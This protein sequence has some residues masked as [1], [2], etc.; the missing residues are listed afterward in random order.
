MLSILHTADFHLDA[1]FAA[2][3]PEQGAVRRGQQRQLLLQLAEL[4]RK[5][6]GDL[7]LLSGDVFDGDAVRPETVD[8][9]K[10]AFAACGAQVCIAPGNHDPYT[11]DSVWHRQTW[12]ENVHIFSGSMEA[13]SFPELH[14]RVW[15]AAFRSSCAENLLRP[16][17][18]AQ[19]G[20]WEIGVFHGDPV[21][22]GNYHAI[23]KETLQTCGL[24]YLALGHIH[25]TSLPQQLG[26]TYYGWPGAAAAR[27]F[28]E[29][30]PRY[31]F[32]VQLS[33]R[34]CET[35]QIPLPG[36]TYETVTVAA[37]DDPEAAVRRVLPADGQDTVC[38]VTLTGEA[39]P[40]DVP[41]LE[42]RLWGL[43]LQLEIRDE[44]VP[45]RDLWADC[46]TPTLRGL[47][48]T[49]L[50]QQHDAGDVHAALAARYLLAALDVP[51]AYISGPAG[52]EHH[53]WNLLWLDGNPCWMDPTWGDPV[54]EGGNANDGPS[55]EYFAMTTEQLLRT[56]TPDDAVPVP[57]CTTE[58]Y[59]YFRKNG[60]YLESY[61][62]RAV[63]AALERA[64]TEG[65]T[66][67]PL[68][69]A[70][71]AYD[72]AVS[73]LFDQGQIYDLLDEASGS[74]GLTLG[75]EQTLWYSENAPMYTVSLFLPV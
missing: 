60:L 43:C 39:E 24:D 53:A 75:R 10:A 70:P 34:G 73:L 17:P 13:F 15:G 61:D 41:A 29:T 69:F 33:D 54:Y 19:D 23:S 72:E 25:K 5:E 68:Q 52:G 67:V 49:E 71:G 38:R 48:L 3:T 45:P 9:M 56:H 50:K 12:P 1:P 7:W 35:R 18:E 55:Y 16:I 66:K 58:A 28:D 32:W 14:C 44:T 64:L 22:P 30:G 57:D 20:F 31:A 11:A 26:R 59:N 8:A 2:L 27:G 46:G 51:C 65:W 36:L 4:C 40:F 21:Y 47:A 74:A 62:P 37:G 6:R 63:T 42:Q